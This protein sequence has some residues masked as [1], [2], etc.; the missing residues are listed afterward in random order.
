MPKTHQLC[1]P[2]NNAS[3]LSILALIFIVKK[4]HPFSLMTKVT[5]LLHRLCKVINK[6]LFTANTA[7]MKALSHTLIT[8]NVYNE[9]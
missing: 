9:L 2:G 4:I 1:T 5:L 7:Q 8:N 3:D 6:H